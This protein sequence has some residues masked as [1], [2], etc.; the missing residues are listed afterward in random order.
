[1]DIEPLRRWELDEG[2]ITF[3]LLSN[4]VLLKQQ[5]GNKKISQANAY[6]LFCNSPTNGYSPPDMEQQFLKSILDFCELEDINDIML[7]TAMMI[8]ELFY[9]SDLLSYEPIT[10]AY[11]EGYIGPDQLKLE[12]FGV[13][14]YNSKNAGID[15]TYLSF[16][17]LV[18]AG[19]GLAGLTLGTHQEIQKLLLK[20]MNQHFQ[21]SDE[22]L[23]SQFNKETLNEVAFRVATQRDGRSAVFS[24]TNSSLDFT[25]IKETEGK[26]IK[27]QNFLCL[28]DIKYFDFAYFTILTLG[29]LKKS[30][31]DKIQGLLRQHQSSGNSFQVDFRN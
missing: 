21:N 29:F 14:L 20:I 24:L 17:R 16:S 6:T 28:E 22:L 5:T 27:S 31:F 30:D 19:P 4:F 9:H 10:L 8:T 1:M 7:K 2:K 25:L 13:I 23:Y 3:T 18:L 12:P 15:K 11:D 26:K